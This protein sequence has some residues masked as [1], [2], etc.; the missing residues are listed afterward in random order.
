MWSHHESPSIPATQA[1]DGVGDRST[2]TTEY[3]DVLSFC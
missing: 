3:R 2:M 1:R